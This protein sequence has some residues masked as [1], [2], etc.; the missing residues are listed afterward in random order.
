MP[1]TRGAQRKSPGETRTG[2]FL[3]PTALNTQTVSPRDNLVSYADGSLDPSI[4]H[5][6]PGGDKAANWLPAPADDCN[7]MKRLS[8][9]KTGAPSILPPGHRT[10]IILPVSRAT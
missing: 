9:P 2:F 1:A 4:R 6:S 5:E 7:Q 10:W 8:W 3:Y